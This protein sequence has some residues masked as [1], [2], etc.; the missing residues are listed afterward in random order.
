MN[1]PRERSAV[2]AAWLEEGPNELP[3]TTRRAIAADSADGKNA[4]NFDL[5][6]G[7]VKRA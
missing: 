4:E 5:G 1:Q 3:D 7:T 6:V 2:V